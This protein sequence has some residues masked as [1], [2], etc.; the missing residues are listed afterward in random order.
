MAGSEKEIEDWWVSFIKSRRSEEQASFHT[1]Q[2]YSS[3]CQVEV[4][5]IDEPLEG[6][7]IFVTRD[8]D[9]PDK[10]VVVNGPYSGE[11]FIEKVAEISEEERWQ[12]KVPPQD[13]KTPPGRDPQRAD[14]LASLISKLTGRL[15]QSIFSDLSSP[16][17]GFLDQG[18]LWPQGSYRILTGNVV[19]IDTSNNTSTQN[20]E[21]DEN[22]EVKQID[23]SSEDSGE[24]EEESPKPA[25]GGFIYP[26]VW[27]DNPPERTFAEKVWDPQFRENE[28]VYEDEILGRDFIAFRDGLLALTIEVP[29]DSSNGDNEGQ[30]NDADTV[31]EILNTVLGIGTIGQRFQWRSLQPR[32]FI[33][34]KI[35][36]EGF[37]NHHAELSTPSGRN[38]LL[39]GE[40]RP[41]DHERGLISSERLGYLLQVTEDIYGESDLHELIDLHLQAHTHFLDD[42]YTASFLLNWTVVEQFVEMITERDLR[43]EH[44]VNRDRRESIFD[45]SHWFIS[46]IL[47]LA[48]VADIIDNGIYSELDRHRSK[49]NDIVHDMETASVERAEDLDHLVS[50]LLCREVNNRLDSTDVEQL[51]HMAI[52]MKPKTRRAFRDG[53][54]KPKKWR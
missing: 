14:V 49:R 29:A 23:E 39:S 11:H 13:F 38:Q 43:D 42:E 33:S 15:E 18:R 4:F 44:N 51:E 53:E 3:P 20:T 34:G 31:L 36:S 17:L 32:E 52:P 25:G 16:G 35:G 12:Q 9:R 22:G 2:D 5:W 41:A 7:L 28:I 10:D 50:E 30:K 6:Q 19:D 48:E 54:Y 46:H 24:K 40:S 26:A 27:I 47:E 1:V 8:R 21:D 37:K 45:G